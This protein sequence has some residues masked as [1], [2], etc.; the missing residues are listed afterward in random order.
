MLSQLSLLSQLQM[1]SKNPVCSYENLC[2]L[3]N[4]CLFVCFTVYSLFCCVVLRVKNND[5]YIR[6][7]SYF[8]IFL[9]FNEGPIPNSVPPQ[10]PHQTWKPRSVTGL[11]RDHAAFW[12]PPNITWNQ[13]AWVIG[14]QCSRSFKYIPGMIFE[15]YNL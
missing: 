6:L 9:R 4:G 8:K 5:I 3:I 7:F 12:I 14:S 13:C 10:W 1:S 15:N 11:G 2:L